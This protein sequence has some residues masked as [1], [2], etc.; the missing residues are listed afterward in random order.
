MFARQ[1]RDV[2]FRYRA[3]VLQ[4]RRITGIGQFSILLG[5]AAFFQKLTGMKYLPYIMQTKLFCVLLS[6][7][8]PRGR[9][10]RKDKKA[11]RVCFL[12]RSLVLSSEFR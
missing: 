1:Y 2:P 10:L 3:L 8:R 11:A 4:D 7:V 9:G 6:L 5:A 12:S